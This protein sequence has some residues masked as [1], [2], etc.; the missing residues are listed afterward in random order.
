MVEGREM[1]WWRGRGAEGMGRGR[2]GGAAGFTLLYVGGLGILGKTPLAAFMA[3]CTSCA[4]A[5][6]SRSRLNWSVMLALPK[7]L[8][9]VISAKPLIWPN[10]RSN[11]VVT[12]ETITSGP[13]PGY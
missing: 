1:T 7:E 6:M 10:C 5:S 2:M 9:E 3:A 11:G 4:A 13:A 8:I 12:D